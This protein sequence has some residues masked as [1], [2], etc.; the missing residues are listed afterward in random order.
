M[1]TISEM[2]AEARARELRERRE[3]RRAA[4]INLIAFT[5]AAAGILA[6]VYMAVLGYLIGA[7]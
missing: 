3:T 5:G 6:L 2:Q 1:R 7:L 4:I